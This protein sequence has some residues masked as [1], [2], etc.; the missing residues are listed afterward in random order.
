MLSQ[1]E[2][3]AETYPDA[4][5]VPVHSKSGNNRIPAA[6]AH[7][8]KNKTGLDTN[9]EI[10]QINKVSRTG[11]K[12]LYRLANRNVYDGYVE[13]GRKYILVD[14]VYSRG[15]SLSELRRYIEQ[16]GGETVQFIALADGG[17]GK[18]V[19]LNQKTER[20]LP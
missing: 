2:K 13:P 8:I 10:I 7:F 18:T 11:H 9:T 5:I 15:G 12:D 6:F 3:L 16:R 4:I 1:I 19:A 14:D 20:E 17:L